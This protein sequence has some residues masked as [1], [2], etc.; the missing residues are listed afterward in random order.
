M[1]ADLVVV[2]TKQLPNIIDTKKSKIS[3]LI[4]HNSSA[5]TKQIKDKPHKETKS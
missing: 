4:T 2:P 3:V 5:F 1:I